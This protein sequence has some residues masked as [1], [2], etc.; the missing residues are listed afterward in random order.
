MLI[1]LVQVALGRDLLY[2]ATAHRHAE[3]KNLREVELKLK[4]HPRLLLRQQHPVFSCGHR[5]RQ[6][7]SLPFIASPATGECVAGVAWLK[8]T[9]LIALSEGPTR[10][11]Y[12][13]GVAAQDSNAGRSTRSAAIPGAF[14]SGSV[15]MLLQCELTLS[16]KALAGPVNAHS[17]LLPINFAMRFTHLTVH[18]DHI[19]QEVL[20]HTSF[21]I[22]WLSIDLVV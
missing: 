12:G 15:G 5:N 10:C 17:R 3:G 16:G 7:A 11:R 18:D 20:V 6:T 4:L 8:A 22:F 19:C 9:L 13:A 1:S 21:N 14:G 2:M